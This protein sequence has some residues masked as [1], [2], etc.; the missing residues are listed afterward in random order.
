ML[1]S[2]DLYTKTCKD[3]KKTFRTESNHTRLCP[4]CKKAHDAETKR[5]KRE[6]ENEQSKKPIRQVFHRVLP[7]TIPIR[8]FTAII[9]RYNRKHN[10]RYTYGQFQLMMFY[11]KISNKDLKECVT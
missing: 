11:G 4:T 5:R 8:E 3:C 10:T 9:E 6:Y 1:R 2:K 7:E